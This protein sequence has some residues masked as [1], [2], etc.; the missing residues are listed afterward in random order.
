LSVCTGVS[1]KDSARERL[2][3]TYIDSLTRLTNPDDSLSALYNIL[4]LSGI[5]NR[6]EAASTLLDFGMRHGND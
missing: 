4:D 2:R 6:A 3:E 1:A 5:D